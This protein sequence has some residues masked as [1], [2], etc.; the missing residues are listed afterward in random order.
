MSPNAESDRGIAKPFLM[1]AAIILVYSLYF[2]Y[3]TSYG[4]NGTRYFTLFDDEMISMRYAKN[5]AEGNGLVWNVGGERVEGFTN[6][7]W[8]FIMAGLHMLPIPA[9]QMSLYIQLLGLLFLLG[10]IYFT[11]RAALVIGRGSNLV[12]VP[13]MCLV[14]FYYPFINWSLQ[15]TEVSALACI[16]T[17]AMW[18]SARNYEKGEWTFGPYALMGIATWVRPDAAVPLLVM[19]LFLSVSDRKWR[20]RHVLVGVAVLIAMLG[21]QTVARFL[22]Y[23]DILPN[24]YYLKLTGYPLMDRMARG[25][26]V[27]KE[28]LPWPLLAL[29]ALAAVWSLFISEWL[30]LF[31]LALFIGQ[32]AYSVYVGGDAWGWWGGMNR[33][34]CIAAPALFIWLCFLVE[35]RLINGAAQIW[36]RAGRNRIVLSVATTII[37]AVAFHQPIKPNFIVAFSLKIPAPDVV[38]NLYQLIL[39]KRIGELTTPE[40]KIAVIWA[41]A[42]PYFTGR[43]AIDI[44]G[45]S[46]RY[47]ARLPSHDLEFYPGHM[48]WDYDYSFGKLAPDVITEI[49][50]EKELAG[51]H[52]R[53]NYLYLP[54]IT[55]YPFGVMRLYFRKG[56]KCVKW[57]AMPRRFPNANWQRE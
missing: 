40:A 48:K 9:N 46:D 23:G 19:T 37:L 13:A 26:F 8:T 42:V 10:T 15:G 57:K 32:L 12:A 34:V 39:A 7:L 18:L 24:T 56:S 41:G 38:S 29:L 6:P 25:V 20:M 22:Y 43:Q 52:L 2:I 51:K 21:T 49:W 11:G 54:I 5:L 28:I 33:Y 44:L 36:K 50:E 55:V 16:L 14:A 17:A 27:L 1:I 35:S 30:V 4:I 45:K 53:E 3:N 31:P 47:V